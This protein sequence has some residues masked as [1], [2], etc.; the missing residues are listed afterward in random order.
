MK[1]IM[2]KLGIAVLISTTFSINAKATTA[3]VF[4]IDMGVYDWDGAHNPA[5]TGV[6]IDEY[7]VRNFFVFDFSTVVLNNIQSAKFIVDFNYGELAPGYSMIYKMSNLST[8][9]SQLVAGGTNR[10]DIYNDLADGMI[11]GSRTLSS[12][13]GTDTDFA[14][15][16]N[17]DGIAALINANVKWAF[18]G[19]LSSTDPAQQA[20]LYGDV[21]NAKL[22]LTYADVTTPVPEPETSG[23][24]LI[25]G[26]LLGAVSLRKSK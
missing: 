9:V 24:L 10:L 2:V 12:L 17:A 8:S 20:M 22:V 7:F 4:A 6:A 21:V 23:M 19:S 25:G 18:G 16:F 1:S 5:R 14:I 13:A 26:L 15:D 3:E 11:Y